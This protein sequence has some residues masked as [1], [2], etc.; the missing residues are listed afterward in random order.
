MQT[1]LHASQ[2]TTGGVERVVLGLATYQARAGLDVVV[3]SPA[4]DLADRARAAGIRWIRWDCVRELGASIPGEVRRLRA[5]VRGVAPEIVHLHSSKAGL[6]GRLALRGRLPTVFQP[7]AWSA[8]AVDGTARRGALVWERQARRWTDLTLYCSQEELQ[9]G[10]R[11]GITGP[12]RVVLNG[13]DLAVFAPAPA[14]ERQRIRHELSLPD[15]PLA[16][17]VGRRCRQKGQDLALAAWQRVRRQLPDAHLVL[18]GEGNT[19]SDAAAG[20][21]A[22]GARTDV[23]SFFHAADLVLAPSRWEGLSLALLEGMACG[24]STVATQVAGA[25]EAL[26][27]GGL[28]PAGAVVPTGAVDA[29]VEA[30]VL[31][32]RD[33]RL[34]AA[35]GRAARTRAEHRFSD[36]S[37]FAAITDCYPTLRAQRQVTPSR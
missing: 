28:P 34:T 21:L 24:R 22:V 12:G 32:L 25:R 20:V 3:A 5:V 11:A 1:V 15:A 18:V 14:A 9:E 4:G 16:V 36:A 31:R 29:V 35:E 17:V 10:R 6:I 13:V 7:H 33:R 2:P 26:L 27:G 37:T 19:D 8:S 30:V 23:G